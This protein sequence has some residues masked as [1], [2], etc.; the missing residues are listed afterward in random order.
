MLAAVVTASVCRAQSEPAHPGLHSTAQRIILDTDIGDDIDDAF[1]LALALSSPQIKLMGIVTAWGDTGLRARLAR[2]FLCETGEANIPVFAGVPTK[3][4][5]VFSQRKWAQASS[6]LKQPPAGAGIDFIL[7]TVRRYPGQ[8]TL[9]AIAPLSNVGA[10]IDKDPATFRKLKKVVLMGGSIHR[11]YDY[12]G[13]P[14]GKPSPEYNIHMDVA[15]ANKLLA[16]GVPIFMLPL[17]ST[18]LD[19]D[20]AKRAQLFDHKT[21]ITNVLSQLY[22]EWRA[23][24]NRRTPVL[25]DAM[26]VAYDVDPKL[27]PMTPMRLHVDSLGY[28]RLADGTPNVNVCLRSDPQKFFHFYMPRVLDAKVT[29]KPASRLC[30]GNRPAR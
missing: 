6:A 4:K 19:L 9:I 1:A 14:N 3:S 22:S 24:T 25:F 2:R 12:L 26:A 30:A 11:G 15:S 16:S 10:L 8:I 17:D 21:S 29:P 20:A 5:T 27:C 18:Q 7:K 13:Q 28:T 23:A